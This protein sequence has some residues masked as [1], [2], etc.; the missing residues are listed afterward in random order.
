MFPGTPQRSEKKA[1]EVPGSGNSGYFVGHRSRTERLR[2]QGHLS[3]R[4]GTPFCL[5]L[6]ARRASDRRICFVIVSV[7]VTPAFCRSLFVAMDMMD[8]MKK[9]VGALA[10]SDTTVK[11]AVIGFSWATFAWDTYLSYRQVGTHFMCKQVVCLTHSLHWE[12]VSGL[13]DDTE[14]AQ[15]TGRRD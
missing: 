13:T 6:Q 8:L 15:S 1:I 4:T 14:C 11:T 2:R 10:M 5:C 3:K 12:I 7:S 9:S